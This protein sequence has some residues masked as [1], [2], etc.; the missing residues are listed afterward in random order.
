MKQ[1]PEEFQ[2]PVIKKVEVWKKI[3]KA[4]EMYKMG[5]DFGAEACDNKFRQLK[6]RF[7]LILAST[8]WGGN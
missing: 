4:T 6:H 1:M 7:I 5:Y 2:S 3:K 8:F